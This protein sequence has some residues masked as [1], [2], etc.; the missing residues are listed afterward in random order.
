MQSS[1]FRN[2][3]RYF[4]NRY[5]AAC[6]SRTIRHAWYRR[7]LTLDR[8]A[9]VMMGLTLRKLG[10]ITVGERSNINPG[11]MLDSRGGSITI[12]KDVDI[13]PEVNIWTLE[14]NL[15]DPDFA[16]QGG[17]V[18]I[19]DFAWVCN[20][21]VILPGVTLGRGCVVA[22]GAVVTKSVEPWTI[23]GGI[24]AKPI[25]RRPQHQHPRKPY[26]PYFL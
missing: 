14:H 7:Y 5:I 15:A 24:P 26:R 23:V 16:T 21:A 19:E 6:P 8:D 1:L 12:G 2:L 11:C 17:S 20:R 18:I 13:A 4:T 10:G 3:I 9:N 22:A 25:G